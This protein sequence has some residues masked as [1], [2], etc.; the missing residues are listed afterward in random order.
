LRI[1]KNISLDQE[2]AKIAGDIEE[3]S[4][5]VRA[6]LLTWDEMGRPPVGDVVKAQ[7]RVR[8][9]QAVSDFRHRV[10]GRANVL[11]CIKHDDS[12]TWITAFPW[13]PNDSS[14][15]PEGALLAKLDYALEALED[16]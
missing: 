8:W 12:G 9:Q 2:T 4:A 1:P 10:W 13:L 5:W 3:F 16:D 11:K 15:H 6:M 7:G 14:V